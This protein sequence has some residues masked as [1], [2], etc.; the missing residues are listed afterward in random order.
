MELSL[1]A[2][3]NQ[4]LESLV[5]MWTLMHPRLLPKELSCLR[6]PKELFPSLKRVQMLMCRL[7]QADF[8]GEL[9]LRPQQL[10]DL[11]PSETEN[12]MEN[13]G[14]LEILTRLQHCTF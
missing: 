11:S 4:M 7:W 3:L 9:K 6:I 14:R 13:A 12:Q 2:Y 5:R 8:Y 1:E 10:Q